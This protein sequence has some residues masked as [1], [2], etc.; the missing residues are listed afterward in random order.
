MT[1]SDAP[2]ILFVCL[3][4]ICRSP[5]AEGVARA[6]AAR[7]GI[8][9]EFDGAGTGAWHIG[10]PPDRRMQAE[11]R[12][13]G[14]D[15][16]GLRARRAEPRDFTEFDLILAMDEDNLR[17]MERMRPRGNTTPVEMFLSY[18]SSGRRSVP[19]PYYEGG[20]EAVL[21]MIEDAAEGLLE[22]I[23]SGEIGAR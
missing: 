12:A 3:G 1:G 9:A 4:N 8:A 21:A 18:G 2:R 19:D 10:E 7:A 17:A 20:F 13:A 15:I 22:K 6:L 11:A 16:S 14:Y 5:T 23:A